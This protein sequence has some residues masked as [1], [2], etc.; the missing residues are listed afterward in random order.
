MQNQVYVLVF[1]TGIFL[2]IIV[3]SRHEWDRH[4]ASLV[5]ISYG[6]YAAAVA[7]LSI[8]GGVSFGQC[9]IEALGLE[10]VFLGGLF[11]SVFTYRLFLHPLNSIPGPLTARLTSLWIIRENI[12]YLKFYVKLRGL[13]D[14]Y[15]DFVRIR[16]WIPEFC[17]S[18]IDP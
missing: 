8:V 1:V 12:P 15:G 6:S 11:G 3:F 2:H 17:S 18:A 16:K 14:Q 10:L 5:L 9:L 13:H 4:M 7:L